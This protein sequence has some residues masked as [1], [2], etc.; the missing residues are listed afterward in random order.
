MVPQSAW[1]KGIVK[2]AEHDTG[3][4]EGIGEAHGFSV[5]DGAAEQKKAEDGHAHAGDGEAVFEV[6]EQEERGSGELDCWVSPCDWLM[7]VAAT[8]AEKNPAEDGDVVEGVDGRGA[9]GAAGA[10]ADD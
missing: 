7:A 3:E 1:L 5:H 10:R 9:A 2:D 4:C 6:A 8:A